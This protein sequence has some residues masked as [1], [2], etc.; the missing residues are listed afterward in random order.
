MVENWKRDL[1][2]NCREMFE[3]CLIGEIKNLDSIWKDME[4]KLILLKTV[5]TPE[6][7]HADL[8]YVKT[9]LIHYVKHRRKH[10]YWKQNYNTL[11]FLSGNFIV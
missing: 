4:E 3:F 9:A 8:Y 11:Q 2:I 1:G 6:Y 10:E 5:Y 7:F